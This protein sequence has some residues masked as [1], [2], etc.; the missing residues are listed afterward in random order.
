MARGRLSPCS[1]CGGQGLLTFE[2]G[3]A[4]EP[5]TD[6]RGTGRVYSDSTLRGL[7]AEMLRQKGV[8]LDPDMR[9]LLVGLDALDERVQALEDDERGA[10]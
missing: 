4:V 3:P 7:F 9:L 6:C 5:C 8:L 2:T 1:S 10:L